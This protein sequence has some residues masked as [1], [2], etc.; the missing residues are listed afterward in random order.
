M[1]TFQVTKLFHAKSCATILVASLMLASCSTE[2]P[3]LKAEP[4]SP[5]QSFY[6]NW[7][8]IDAMVK[9]GT[10]TKVT[11]R[12]YLRHL[13]GKKL[14]TLDGYPYNDPCSIHDFS[15]EFILLSVDNK[16]EF[17]A[18]LEHVVSDTDYINKAIPHL[19]GSALC[20]GSD[21]SSWIV[22]F[23]DNNGILK[24]AYARAGK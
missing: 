18:F 20:L 24:E 6:D 3:I 8:H 21:A 10:T 1:K 22:M 14:T 23:F 15:T 13:Y 9:S 2:P 19:T 7:S 16:R 11:A 17:R 4:Y 12:R 5:P